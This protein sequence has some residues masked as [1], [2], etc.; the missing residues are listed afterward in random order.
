MSI[1][2]DLIAKNVLDGMININETRRN[3]DASIDESRCIV[4]TEAMINQ[5][6]NQFNYNVGRVSDGK[7]IRL[8]ET[9][10][11]FKVTI[12]ISMIDKGQNL[13]S[14]IYRANEIAENGFASTIA[15]VD[16]LK[17]PDN[18]VLLYPTISNTD[19]FIPLK[20]IN[21]S[22]SEV[23]IERKKYNKFPY[24]RHYEKVTSGQVFTIPLDETKFSRAVIKERTVLIF[25]N[26]RLYMGS[27]TVHIENNEIIVSLFQELTNGELEIIVDS[28]VTYFL[29]QPAMEQGSI[30]VFEIPETYIDS[31]HGPVSKF[32]CYFFADG[33]RL[34]ND[35]IVQEGRLHFT[36]NFNRPST[37]TLAMFVTDIGYITDSKET[38]YGS[39]YYLYNMTGTSPLSNIF[40]GLPS[41]TIFDD[42][43]DFKEVLSSHNIRYARQQINSF[44]EEYYSLSSPEEKVKYSLE[45]RPYLMRTFLENYGKKIYTYTVDY[46]GNDP[47][48][49]IGLPSIYEIDQDHVYDI[50]INTMH[51]AS[52]DIEII[53]KNIT[54]IFKIPSKLFRTGKNIVEINAIDNNDV[55]YVEIH[56][57]DI[58]TENGALRSR[59]PLFTRFSSLDDIYV[60]EKNSSSPELMYPNDKNT[61]YIHFPYVTIDQDEGGNELVI[62]YNRMPDNDIIIYNSNFTTFVHYEKP[63][64]STALDIIIPIYTGTT[65]NP[66][67]YIPKGR[68]E[69]Y[70]G[71]NKLIQG[72]D[73]YIKHPINESKAAGSFIVIKRAIL[74][75]TVFDIYISNIVTK[76]I[77]EG[78]GYF[79]N[80]PYGL[81]YLGNLTFPFSLKYL[82]VYINNKKCTEADI[83]IL[84]D[85]L[86]RIHSL[87]VPMFD[88]LVESTFTVEDEYLDPFLSIYKEDDFEKYI[89]SLF[90][91][92]Y[93]DRP[94]VPGET[95][96]DYNAIYKSFVDS[97]DSVNK[98][99]NPVARESEWIPSHNSDPGVIG[100][101]NDGTAMGGADIYTS[102]IAGEMYVV[103]GEGGRV[104]SCNV[105]SRI[106]NDYDSE[107]PFTSNGTH[108]EGNITSSALYKGYLIFSTDKGEIGFYNTIDHKWA[109]PGDK[110]SGI[111]L[112]LL[113]P[114]HFP[115]AIYKI[116]TI[117]DKLIIMG[118]GGNVA[119][120]NLKG[121]T[122]YAYTDYSRTDA[123]TAEGVMDDI[124]DAYVY[125]YY[126]NGEYRTVLI[127]VGKNGQIASGYYHTNLW[128]KPDG[129]R[130]NPLY[131]G[132]DVFH[133][134]S[135]REYTDINAVL[136]YLNYLVL[137]GKNG[138]V[139]LYD[140]DKREALG[141]G[142]L[143]NVSNDGKHS[144]YEDTNAAIIYDS[145]ILVTG[146]NLGKVS[147][148]FG[149]NE[150]WNESNGTRGIVSNGYDMGGNDI[151][152]ITYTFVDTNYMIFAGQN[153][154][155]ASYNVDTH[156]L[157]FRF[158]PYK[159]AF[160]L[161]Y[162]TPGNAYINTA[163][164]LPEEVIS[165]FSIYKESNDYN[166][167]IFLANGDLDLIADIDMNDNGRYPKSYQARSE[168]MAKFI[169]SLPDK[170]YSVSEVFSEYMNSH[171]KHILYPWD[172]IL[173]ASGDEI[174]GEE[175]IDIANSE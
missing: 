110:S 148:Y 132:S 163:W 90:R 152:T 153:G 154:K 79:R 2:T 44:L 86:I 16:G 140:L 77:I 172:L 109:Y 64:A 126:V 73:Y 70:A 171:H 150:H 143:R 165:L 82:D 124:Y 43:I 168:Y 25:I 33:K 141:V 5:S 65:I 111:N 40:K 121:N 10:I 84:S 103:A 1:V 48:V 9:E 166:Y 158:N 50:N 138:L 91:G 93:F 7:L 116:L 135:S 164:D 37:A 123:L 76:K 114:S 32:S 106:W 98:V 85:K 12:N 6:I 88:L 3:I 13:R 26:K 62:T 122:W 11:Y 151:Y 34:L 136:G 125:N 102:I 21:R 58:R 61:G 42:N 17:I 31:I 35:S 27:R 128:T 175:D 170:D 131:S 60:L 100:I 24:I 145:A 149:E 78:E 146:S 107:K 54:D 94:Y 173:L 66:V 18:E 8:D 53:N 30:G 87:P 23:L 45:G 59:I 22:G 63:I 95:N 41:N 81:F 67:P 105:H 99:P 127:T 104:A 36:Y 39:D 144:G 174:E 147:S 46:N 162:T 55:E 120:Y 161:W 56:P 28:G 108:F 68:V 74:P 169:H 92:V 47:F 72:I 117:N 4:F 167:D 19:V 119:T 160:L 101:H 157:A 38:F 52:N 130:H 139:T 134:G 156:E 14:F 71:N 115:G 96:P 75:G 83:D 113:S 69:V 57:S 129:T 97:V 20:Y 118:E 142:D 159:T 89:E 80:N 155:V 51:I 137:F 133:D 112:N 29:I 49:V 15:Y